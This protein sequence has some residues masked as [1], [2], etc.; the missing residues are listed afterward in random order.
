MPE[1]PDVEIFR[2]YLDATAL[3]QKIARVSV[4]NRTVLRHISPRAIARNLKGRKIQSSARHGKFLFGQLDNNGSAIF[5]FGMTG[6]LKYF[7][8]QA[9]EPKHTRLRME[10]SNGSFLGYVC[11]RMFG[12]VDYTIDVHRYIKE[13]GLGPDALAVSREQFK[14]RLSGK[15]SPIKTVLM[16][17]KVLAGIGNV[18]SDEILFQARVHPEQ[19]VNRLSE[20]TLDI[21]YKVMKSVL[22][23]TISYQANPDR[24]PKTWLLPHREKAAKCPRCGKGVHRLTINQRSAYICPNCQRQKRLSTDQKPEE[25]V[26]KRPRA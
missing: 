18:Y 24:V 17:Q 12:E 14:N 16:D 9:D 19:R 10:F 25:V 21:V 2:R 22:K 3:N 4:K 15:K 23:K 7:K 5:H 11:S 20:R 1:L 13:R 26:G 8:D 6:F